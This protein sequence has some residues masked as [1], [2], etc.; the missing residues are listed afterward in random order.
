ML[1][2]RHHFHAGNFADIHKHFCLYHC[3]QYFN[4]K[5]K[6]YLYHD[7]HGGAGLYDTS[8][9]DAQ[10]NR[11]AATGIEALEKQT[12]L[13]AEL[14]EFISCIRTIAPAPLYPGSPL[15]AAH[16]LRPD[17]TL[18]TCERHPSDYPIL[19]NNL[20]NKRKKHTL[21]QASDGYQ[22]LIASLPPPQHRALILIDPPYEE[23]QDYQRI[24]H[25]LERSFKRFSQA[26]ILIW[27]PQLQ[28]LEACE[29]PQQLIHLAEK[30][31][32]DY[33]QSQLTIK[34]PSPDGYGMHGSYMTLIN[35]PYL[36]PQQLANAQDAL[37]TALAQDT[38][39]QHQL[40]SHIR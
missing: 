4:R 39:T 1:S 10:K 34:A 27:H 7:T 13:P 6:S 28:R 35:P 22:D 12:T 38:H 24:I 30:F 8:H 25:T 33:L 37:I 18:R 26:T 11:E 23:K 14:V 20:K 31:D 16:L 36:L 29:L 17:D 21:I 19:C 5:A 9:A 15:I 40:N 3:L 32:L 2:Y